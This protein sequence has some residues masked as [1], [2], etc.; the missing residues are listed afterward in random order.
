MSSTGDGDNGEGASAPLR[1]SDPFDAHSDDASDVEDPGLPRNADAA[2]LSE[3][4]FLS[5]DTSAQ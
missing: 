5:E 3:E 4:D 1:P 2:L